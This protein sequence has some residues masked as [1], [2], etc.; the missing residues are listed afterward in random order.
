MDTPDPI[1]YEITR[2]GKTL[3]SVP[4]D[5]LEKTADAPPKYIF[6]KKGKFVLEIFVHALEAEPIPKF[7]RTPEERVAWK[8]TVRKVNAA[9]ALPHLE[10]D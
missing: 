3:E 7:P 4:A 9:N 6:R 5:S 1:R 8:E 10:K 2:S